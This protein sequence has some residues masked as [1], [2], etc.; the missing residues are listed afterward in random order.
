[1]TTEIHKNQPGNETLDKIVE[2]SLLYDFY[3]E[4]LKD[5]KKQ[6]FEDYV[7]NDLSLSEIAEEAGISR[8][9][10]YDLVKR[11]SKEL[12]EYE[13]KLRL[14]EKFEYTKNK[15]NQI[16]ELSDQIEEDL[17]KDVMMTEECQ[18]ANLERI[19][20]IQELSKA[21]QKNY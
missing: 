18:N 11:C 9:G 3:G 17:S 16:I 12:Q 1:M 10:V 5:H 4:L 20:A 2:L 21:I 15:V 8:Q 19:Q 13:K 6:V 14:V 7:L